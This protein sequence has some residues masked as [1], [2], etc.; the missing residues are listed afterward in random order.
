MKIYLAG[1]L[2]TVAERAFNTDLARELRNLGHD[3]WLPQDNEPRDR[4]AS[5][6]FDADVAGIRWSEVI[7]GNMDGPDPDSGTAWECGCGWAWGKP[8]LLFRT[9]MRGADDGGLA[10]FNIMLAASAATIVPIAFGD[11]IAVIAGKIDS[12]LRLIPVGRS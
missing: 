9:D 4:T 6:I 3:V 10:P 2:F 5:A 11:T 7:V 8:S 1:P 12:M